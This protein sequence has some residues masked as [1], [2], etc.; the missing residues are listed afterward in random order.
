MANILG[1]L[2]FI[3]LTIWIAIISTCG[4]KH[5]YNLWR[6]NDRK[7][8]KQIDMLS[9]DALSII[10]AMYNSS[11]YTMKLELSCATTVILQSIGFISRPNIGTGLGFE[12]DYFLEPWVIKCLKKHSQ[13]FKE[14]LEQK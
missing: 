9:D 8:Q 2:F 12:F 7:C 1:P 13:K 5:L 11:S 6:F 3:L 14:R 4:F 10:L